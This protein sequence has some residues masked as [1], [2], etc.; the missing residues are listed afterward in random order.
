MNKLAIQNRSHWKYFAWGFIN[1]LF[2][3][4]S[5]RYNLDISESGVYSI[6]LN[7]FKPALQN[8]N[9]STTWITVLLLLLSVIGIVSLVF[10]VITIYKKGWAVSLIASLGFL[11]IMSLIFGLDTLGITLL[12]IGVAMVH[13]FST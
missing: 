8:L 7:S 2:I 11:S 13:I 12:L 10:E 5:L 4:V 1:G 3:S 9:F 6:V